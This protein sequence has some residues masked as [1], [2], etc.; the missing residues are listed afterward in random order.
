LGLAVPDWKALRSHKFFIRLSAIGNWPAQRIVPVHETV[1][2]V[3][4][5]REAGAV[6]LHRNKEHASVEDK[7]ISLANFSSGASL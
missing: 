1:D 6:L 5:E 4:L 2:C 3:Q 7:K